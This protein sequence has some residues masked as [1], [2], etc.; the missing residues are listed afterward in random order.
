[1]HTHRIDVFHVADGNTVARGITHNLVLNLLPAGNAALH[2]HLVDTAQTQAVGQ[3]IHQ[4][5]LVVG[6]SAA[7]SPKGKGRTQHNRVADGVG[8]LDTILHVVYHSGRGAGLADLLHGILERLAVLR[9]EDRLGGGSDQFHAMLF[10][11]TGLRQLHTQIQPGL[12]AQGGKDAVRLFL[13]NDL[14]QHLRCQRLNINLISDILI[15]HDG[16]RVGIDQ[17]HL[18]SFFLQGATGL[19]TRVVELRCLTD[20]NRAGADN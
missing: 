12:S 5:L 3:D 14:L 15:C 4:F 13:E 19:G 18:N 8:K 6:D 16:R 10:Q 20:H 7:A 17:H 9:L 11:E 1:M 2:Q